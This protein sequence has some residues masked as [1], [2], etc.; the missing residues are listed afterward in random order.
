MA[1]S[2]H[3]LDFDSP[4]A[5]LLKQI[6]AYRLLIVATTFPTAD[7]VDAFNSYCKHAIATSIHNSA[8]V[9]EQ[10]TIVNN[11]LHYVEQTYFVKYPPTLT[12]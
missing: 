7:M 6:N 11:Y 2:Y 8:L 1:T 12:T 5:H 9:A 3:D 10:Q 4:S